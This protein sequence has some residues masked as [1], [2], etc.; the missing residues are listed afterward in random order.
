MT[1]GTQDRWRPALAGR[2]SLAFEELTALF[3]PGAED[4]RA[5]AATLARLLDELEAEILCRFPRGASSAAPLRSRDPLAWFRREVQRIPALDREEELRFC[6]A[7]DLA[8]IRLRRALAAAGLDPERVSLDTLGQGADC[9]SCVPGRERLCYACAPAA[10]APG[11]RRRIRTRTQEFQRIRNELVERNLGL[12]LRLLERYR[13]V[14]VP[15]EDLVQEANAS[16]FRAVENFDY[17]RGVRFRTYAA[18]WV[19]QAFLNAIYNQSRTVRVPAYIQ[20]AMKKIH[21]AAGSVEEGLRD[22]VALSRASGVPEDLVVSALTGNRFTLS[23]DRAL[24]A[25]EDGESLACLVEGEVAPPEET[26]DGDAESRA[27]VNHLQEALHG[28]SLREQRILELRFGL[29]GERP[30]TLAEVGEEMGVSLE[31][32]RQIQKAALE[33]LRAGRHAE[34]LEQ[35]A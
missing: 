2:G 7:L 26:V 12:V 1:A 15:V 35:F 8:R 16:L 21:D 24:T 19:N 33:K 11:L 10:V 4:C 22:P 31:R 20:K 18:Y 27:L 3:E 32:V 30:R 17:E 9:M 28:L 6:M 13:H 5:Q 34:L 29:R 23:L 25:G 14:A